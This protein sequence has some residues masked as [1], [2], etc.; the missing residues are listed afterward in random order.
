MWFLI[1]FRVKLLV[2]LH[3]GGAL[4]SRNVPVYL[5]EHMY[6]KEDNMIQKYKENNWTEKV[7]T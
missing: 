7:L 6:Q 3:R 2:S 4:I 5:W 1:Q